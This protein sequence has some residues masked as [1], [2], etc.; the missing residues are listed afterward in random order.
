MAIYNFSLLLRLLENSNLR[1]ISKLLCII[2]YNNSN[3]F[4]SGSVGIC[5]LNSN[6]IAQYLADLSQYGKTVWIHTI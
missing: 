5:S 1:K 6:I 4:S 3:Y 2:A